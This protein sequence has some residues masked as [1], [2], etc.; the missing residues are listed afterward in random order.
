M[1]KPEV[2]VENDAT[3]HTR[4]GMVTGLA[5]VHVSWYVALTG[6]LLQLHAVPAITVPPLPGQSV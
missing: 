2:A 4:F 5:I 1:I 6:M 3:S